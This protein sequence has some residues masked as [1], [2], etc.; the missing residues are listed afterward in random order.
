MN[1]VKREGFKFGIGTVLAFLLTFG[2]PGV[3]RANESV[4]IVNL[5]LANSIQMA[6]DMDAGLDLL[7]DQIIIER[8]DYEDSLDQY[9]EYQKNRSLFASMSNLERAK[10]GNEYYVIQSLAS[11]QKAVRDL[12]EAQQN[13]EY[14]IT[15]RWYALLLADENLTL[16]VSARD[17]A[18]SNLT[19]VEK[20]VELGD[21]VLLDATLATNRL[22]AAEDMVHSR[23]EDVW[24][25]QMRFKHLLGLELQQEIHLNGSWSDLSIPKSSQSINQDEFLA[26]LMQSN[27]VVL[28]SKTSLELESIQFDLFVS[29]YHR[30]N[31]E[32]EDYQ[33]R[34]DQAHLTYDNAI[35]DAL[36]G[37]YEDYYGLLRTERYQEEMLRERA[38]QETLY[39]QT[40]L[41]Y[42]LGETS[43]NELLVAEENL[44]SNAVQLNQA[45]MDLLL[46]YMHW[47]MMYE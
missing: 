8:D 1:I 4:D 2:I 21:A 16:A 46:S 19:L 22:L 40:E 23:Q 28:E 34:Y 18:E 47:M 27:S 35:H 29:I 7:R 45:D 26:G 3:S 9:Q 37:I 32:F 39:E 30:V 31:K 42:S 33:Y 44:F 6:K 13:I 15:Q 36:L 41:L 25:A 38:Y 10:V 11:Y 43:L 20:K 5:D 14:E 12:E 17:R 24:L